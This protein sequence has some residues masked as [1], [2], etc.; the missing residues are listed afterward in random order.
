MVGLAVP[1]PA[2]IQDMSM[3][4]KKAVIK[5]MLAERG[6]DP[7]TEGI[8]VATLLPTI[9]GLCIGNDSKTAAELSW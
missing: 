1:Q 3:N 5:K 8:K 4:K 9:T 6:E 7:E 2:A